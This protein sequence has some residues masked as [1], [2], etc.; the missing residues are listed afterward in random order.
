MKKTSLIVAFFSIL[1]SIGNIFLEFKI[2]ITIISFLI[3]TVNYIIYKYCKNIIVVKSTLTF[4]AFLFFN[5][6]WIHNFGSVGPALISSFFLI[7]FITKFYNGRSLV[8]LLL[9]FLVNI[10]VFFYIDFQSNFYFG[11]YSTDEKRLIDLY[12]SFIITSTVIVLYVYNTKIN[13][14][15]E[16]ENAR[17]SDS[18]KTA[19]LENISH[20]LRTPLNA[21]IGLSGI[22]INKEISAEKKKYYSQIII[23]NNNYLLSLFDNII[24]ASK[25]ESNQL[26]FNIS[27]LSLKE[28]FTDSKT[29][30]EKELEHRSKHE[31]RV[32]LD[33]PKHDT[34]ITSDKYRISQVLNNLLS[35][36]VKFTSFGQITLGFVVKD[37]FI[38]C[39]VSDTGK[40]I[41]NEKY[42]LIFKRFSR[43]N[44]DSELGIRGTGMGLYISKRII[45]IIGG[46]MFF[47]SEYGKGT[48]FTFTLPIK[49]IDVE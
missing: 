5:L 33:I 29:Y 39:F 17:K 3:A 28:L 48:K 14:Y 11:T 20:E 40:G 7:V 26:D 44:D 32:I 34:I 8:F 12:M 36:A 38:E 19:F 42:E 22:I 18:L 45:E 21:I 4:F 46:E 49:P 10:T 6:L 9:L 37:N 2:E 24:D 43:I 1:A 25:I 27:I 41:K 16:V 23:D 13:Y 47:D 15:S 30:I 31:I 35:N